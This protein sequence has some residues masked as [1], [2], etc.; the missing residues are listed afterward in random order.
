MYTKISDL[1]IGMGN[2]KI[3]AKVIE[4]DEPKEVMTKFGTTITL[5]NVVIKDDYGQIKLVLWGKQSE[6][7]NNGDVI[8]IT[9]GFVKDFRGELQVGVGR[10][11]EVKVVK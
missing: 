7:I 11:E 5:T 2:L 10:G 1:K 8:E 6:G 9:N 4:I 3:K